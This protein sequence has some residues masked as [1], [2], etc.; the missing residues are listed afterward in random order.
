MKPLIPYILLAI[1]PILGI[2]QQQDSIMVNGEW[3]VPKEKKTTKFIFSF[4]GRRSFVLD[5][6]VKFSGLRIGIE[7]DEV[8]DVGL[9]FYSTRNP[10]RQTLKDQPIDVE[11]E[12][13]YTTLFYQ[14]AFF[15]TDK[16]ELA[17][18]FHIG[19]GKAN[20]KLFHTDTDDIIILGDGSKAEIRDL[21]FGISE[22]GLE[23]QYKIFPWF[24]LG[25]GVGYRF[26]LTSSED[27]KHVFNAPTYSFKVKIFLGQ[28][29]KT[30][31]K[32]IKDTPKSEDHESSS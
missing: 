15:H 19:S 17:V 21:P 3:V 32:T 4:D 26:A 2:A 28:L 20:L 10:V 12:F 30:I 18:P 6:P 5:Q 25:S 27:A 7:Y 1:I 22:F 14:Y 31:K 24:G 9:G 16:W 29:Y 13:N 8:H 23:A 11:V